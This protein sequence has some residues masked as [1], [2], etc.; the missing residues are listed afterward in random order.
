[1]ELLLFGICLSLSL[2][3][4]I[5]VKVILLIRVTCYNVMNKLSLLT[6]TLLVTTMKNVKY[7]MTLLGE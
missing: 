4:P 6:R 3:H 2:L 5:V 7:A 1:V